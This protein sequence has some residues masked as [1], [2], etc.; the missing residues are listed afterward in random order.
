MLPVDLYP[1]Q[2]HVDYQVPGTKVHINACLPPSVT[3]H[4]QFE[5]AQMQMVKIDDKSMIGMGNPCRMPHWAGFF[6]GG[7]VPS[8]FLSWP[9]LYLSLL[10]TC[11]RKTQ[12]RGHIL[13]AG[14]SPPSPLR[15]VPRIFIVKRL[16]LVLASSTADSRRSVPTHALQARSAVDPFFFFGSKQI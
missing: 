1:W 4:V 6:L 8:H 11:G 9:V 13:L 7:G 5:Y 15:I 12:I 3:F 14:S 16:E 10:H 2:T